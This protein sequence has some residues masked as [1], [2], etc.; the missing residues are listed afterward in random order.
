MVWLVHQKGGFP[1][2]DSQP[3]PG[4]F[5]EV[6]VKAVSFYALGGVAMAA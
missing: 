1:R 4:F 5:L 2:E 3:N 6:G